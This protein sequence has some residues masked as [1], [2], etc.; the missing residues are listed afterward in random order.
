M[1]YAVADCSKM[2]TMGIDSSSEAKNPISV[3]N[4]VTISVYSSELQVHICTSA[5][6]SLSFI[7]AESFAAPCFRARFGFS[8]HYGSLLAHII[9]IDP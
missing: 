5:M 4:Y 3:N 1:Q 6:N 2:L 7:S 9:L 8:S